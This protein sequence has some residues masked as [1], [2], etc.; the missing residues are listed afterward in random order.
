MFF[1][2]IIEENK[3][4]LHQAIGCQVRDWSPHKD[5]LFVSALGLRPTV[6]SPD[7][8][9]GPTL[10]VGGCRPVP[11][12]ELHARS[13]GLFRLPSCK[14]RASG[15]TGQASVSGGNVGWTSS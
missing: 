7:R 5:L 2:H 13:A 6:L 14:L 11:S 12:K 8:A 4:R 9:R 15:L 3:L 1:K 10:L